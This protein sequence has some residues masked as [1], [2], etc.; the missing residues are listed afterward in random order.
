[1][2]IRVASFHFRNRQIYKGFLKFIKG[3]ITWWY[4]Q[5]ICSK[6]IFGLNLVVG[7]QLLR[8]WRFFKVFGPYQNTKAKTYNARWWSESAVLLCCQPSQLGTWESQ[9]HPPVWSPNICNVL[10]RAEE[11]DEYKKWVSSAAVLPA[12]SARNWNLPWLQPYFKS[13]TGEI[14]KGETCALESTTTLVL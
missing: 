5:I 4:F 13:S 14:P 12:F 2:N 9:D 11:A 1:M 6:L 7:A 10:G 3:K 8:S